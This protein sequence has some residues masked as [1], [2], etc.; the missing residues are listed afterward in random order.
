MKNFNKKLIIFGR[1]LSPVWAGLFFFSKNK[2]SKNINKILIIDFHLIGDIILLI[3]LLREFKKKYP[4]SKITLAAG[5]WAHEILKGESLIDSYIEVKAPWVKYGQGFTGWKNLFSVLMRLKKIKWDIGV[6]VR[7]DFRQILC[8]FIIGA[9]YRLGL[10]LSG[11][12]ILLTDV[13]RDDCNDRHIID[14]HLQIFQL[15][16]PE[17]IA[18]DAPKITLTDDETI[19]A[20]KIKPFIGFHFGASLPLKRMPIGSAISLI[21]SVDYENNNIVL[22]IAPDSLTESKVIYD[23]L[24]LDLKRN[25]ELWSGSL[26]EMIV[27]LSRAITLHAMDSGAAHIA[28][29]LG[30]ETI[31]YFGPTKPLFSKP[32]GQKVHIVEKLGMQC[33]P[34][35]QLKCSNKNKQAC[36][37]FK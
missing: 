37:V 26:R 29:A 9:V 28:A 31:V 11:A 30:V 17:T 16:S 25:I 10:D 36:L 18:F 12:D 20:G 34:C 19:A 33:R 1:I 7:G 8:L 32:I 13:A 14:H 4:H 27:K 23:Q 6:E 3:P 35:N 2:I 15:I 22:F 5:P 24:P 21:S